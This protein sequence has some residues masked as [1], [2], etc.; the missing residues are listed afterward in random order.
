MIIA[1]QDGLFLENEVFANQLPAAILETIFM[2]AATGLI[3][4]LL[5]LPLGIALHNLGPRGLAPRSATYRVVSILVDIGR[6]IPFIVLMISLIPFTRFMVGTALGWQAAVVPLSVGAIP[7]FA[8][9]VENALREV[10]AGKVE[11][12]KMMGAS[13]RHIMRQVQVREAL[14]G[15]VGGFTVT[16]V[17]L[18]SYTAMAGA[19]G[20]GGLGALAYNYGYQR[21]QGD[22]MLACVVLLV[23]IVAILQWTGDRVS[24]T[25]D[26]R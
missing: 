8:R 11:A 3:V 16:L 26:H 20:G 18:I 6:S 7:F 22:T 24:R 13:S 17:A 12:V 10:D 25:I 2:T 19:V 15:I 1:A 4:A 9:L 5:G 23:I 14:P 21:Y